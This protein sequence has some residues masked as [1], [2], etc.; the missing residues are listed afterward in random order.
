MHET[1]KHGNCYFTR[2]SASY[3]RPM[4]VDCGAQ[5]L[6][7]VMNSLSARP[8]TGVNH[9]RVRAAVDTYM[10]SSFKNNEM[11]DNLS[12]YNIYVRHCAW[13]IGRCAHLLLNHL[14]SRLMA[15]V[16]RIPY[17]SAPA[18]PD[19]DQSAQPNC[20]CQLSGYIRTRSS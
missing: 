12:V 10:P 4:G 11:F 19:R 16:V 1:P 2:A 15:H 5:V 13:I 8:R 7:T 17:A 6:L 20:V 9:F 14:P 18:P 3:V